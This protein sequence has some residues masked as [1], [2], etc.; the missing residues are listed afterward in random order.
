MAWIHRLSDLNVEKK[1][2]T[3][4]NCGL[5]DVYLHDKGG[6]RSRWHCG[7]ARRIRARARAKTPAHKAYMKKYKKQWTLLH[8]DNVSKM[9]RRSLLKAHGLTDDDYLKMVDERSGR[10]DLCQEVAKLCVDHDH[11]TM[12]IRGL[13]CSHCNLALGFFRD[14][15]EVAARVP[16]YLAA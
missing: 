15:P 8:K 12:R 10:C 14:R 2:A 9:N 5:I 7:E 3:C 6:G 4:S 1:M 11:K 13:L 16:A